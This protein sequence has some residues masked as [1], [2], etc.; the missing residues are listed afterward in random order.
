MDHNSTKEKN[1]DSKEK[2]HHSEITIPVLPLALGI[3]ALLAGVALLFVVGASSKKKITDLAPPSTTSTFGNESLNRWIRVEGAPEKVLGVSGNDLPGSVRGFR[4]AKGMAAP[5]RPFEMQQHEV[6]WEELD[7][8]LAMNPGQTVPSASQ[9]LTKEARKSLP[10]TFVPFSVARDYCRAIGGSLPTEEQWEFAAR[11]P[12]LN[13]FPW[14]NA[15]PD[16][17]QVNAFKGKDAKPA[18]VMTNA[19]DRTEGPA[20]KAIYDLAGNAQE[21]TSSVWGNDSS[22]E[23]NSWV[24]NEGTVVY[25]IRGFPLDRDVPGRIDELSMAY[26]D[27]VCATGDCS[28]LSAGAPARDRAR[29]PKIELWAGADSATKEALE[30]RRELEKTNVLMALSKCFFDR[31]SAKVTIKAA[32]ESFCPRVEH[33]PTNGKCDGQA[34]YSAPLVTMSGELSETTLKCVNYALH[35]VSV[36]NVTGNLPET[37]FSYALLVETNPMQPREHIGFRCAREISSP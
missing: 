3:G 20:D 31:T 36:A 21:W 33:L 26:R 25:A 19:Q 34:A 23:D 35:N 17:S 4:P 18:N 15:A 32:K 7:A 2:S 24:D 22:G 16:F 12:A 8:W 10:A 1:A 5:T 6:T 37:Q 9:E 13:H 27:W 30:W 29:R 28:P 11:G 14:G